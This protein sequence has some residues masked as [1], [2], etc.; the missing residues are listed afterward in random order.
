MTDPISTGI[1]AGKAL[2]DV[3]RYVDG[4][5]TDKDDAAYRK[6]LRH[7]TDYRMLT[8]EFEAEYAGAVI[9]SAEQLRKSILDTTGDL[10]DSSKLEEA[11]FA[12]GQAVRRFLSPST[13]LKNQFAMNLIC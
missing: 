7:L 12:L 4:K 2:F 6:F 5:L 9:K 10:S 11:F 13:Q 1:T 3:L 8:S